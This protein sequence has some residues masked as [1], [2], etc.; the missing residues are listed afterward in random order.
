VD[1]ELL[2]VLLT[3]PYYRRMPPKSTAKELFHA[4][5]MRAMVGE[6]DVR[7]A[8]HDPIGHRRGKRLH[9]RPAD[10]GAAPLHLPAPARSFPSRMTITAA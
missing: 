6:R 9:P 2:A 4:G 5:Y 8:R 3:E 7:P 1:A 10:P